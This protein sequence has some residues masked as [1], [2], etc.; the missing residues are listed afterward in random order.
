ME[1]ATA[2]RNEVHLYLFN[3][4]DGTQFDKARALRVTASLPDREIGPLRLRA[5]RTGPGHY[6]I[7]RADLVPGG[8]WRLEIGVLVSEFDELTTDVEV[9]VR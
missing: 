1:P 3:R 4:K 8:D 7:R 6:T 9:P 2:G 5:R